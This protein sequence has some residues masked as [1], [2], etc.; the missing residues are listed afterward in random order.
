MCGGLGIGLSG[1]NFLLT[2]NEKLSL[3]LEHPHKSLA[4]QHT[5]IASTLHMDRH[6]QIPRAHWSAS[7]LQEK[8]MS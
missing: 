5:L 7:E 8:Q 4:W 3:N 6:K 1:G 2:K